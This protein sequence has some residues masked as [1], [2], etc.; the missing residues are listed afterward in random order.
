[1]QLILI[2][3]MLV[4]LIKGHGEMAHLNAILGEL[5]CKGQ[6]NI[7]TTT[8]YFSTVCTGADSIDSP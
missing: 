2:L 4:L 1:M 5:Y 8:R 3:L 6:L 7:I